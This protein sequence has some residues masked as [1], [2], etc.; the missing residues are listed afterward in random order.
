[1]T[2]AR[3]VSEAWASLSVT[4]VRPIESR[5]GRIGVGNRL[6]VGEGSGEET[7]GP[8]LRVA[9]RIEKHHRYLWV[10]GLEPDEMIGQIALARVDQDCQRLVERSAARSLAT[11]AWW[12][13]D[14]QV[15]HPVT[16]LECGRA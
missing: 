12:A 9:A 4:S 5:S 16:A 7:L 15:R 8:V 1:V 6:P 10:A 11:S 3:R 14:T 13:A 2:P